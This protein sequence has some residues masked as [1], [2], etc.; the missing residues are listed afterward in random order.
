MEHSGLLSTPR[1][2]KE[3]LQCENGDHRSA[4]TSRKG[5][6]YSGQ[7][8]AVNRRLDR[9]RRE[10]CSARDHDARDASLA[11]LHDV[12]AAGFQHHRCIIDALTVDAHGALLDLAHGFARAG[13]EP[14]T[15]ERVPDA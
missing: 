15:L 12:T 3:R 11:D 10:P 4:A 7:S 13:D 6:Q 2:P 14:G 5:A 1:A 9:G 8:P